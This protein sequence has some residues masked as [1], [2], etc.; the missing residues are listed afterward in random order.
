MKP[1]RKKGLKILAIDTSVLIAFLV[2]NDP[3]HKRAVEDLR[4]VDI[5]VLPSEVVIET[6]L[7]LRHHNKSFRGLTEFLKSSNTI[8]VPVDEEILQKALEMSEEDKRHF[9]DILIYLTAKAY[10]LEFLTYDEKF[11]RKYG[12]SR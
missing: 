1:L 10:G 11:L 3:H 8:V 6:A 2:E 4:A 9:V 7:Y 12:E 5:L